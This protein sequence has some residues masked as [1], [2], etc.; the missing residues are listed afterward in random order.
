MRRADPRS[1]R[2]RAPATARWWSSSST[3]APIR[4]LTSMRLGTRRRRPRRKE[5]RALLMAR[6]GRLDC[7]DLVWLNED[8]EVVRRVTAD[9]SE[10][11][12]GCG[13]VFTAAATLGKRDLVVRLLNAGARVPPVLT[14]CRSY[15][16]ENAGILR[17]LLADG[18]LDPE[19]AR[20]AARDA[21]PRDVRPRRPRATARDSRRVC[22]DSARRGR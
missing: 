15:L 7:Y 18:G 12:A 13:G 19:S 10:A 8:D 6:G 14:A 16:L 1:I 17:L 5:L 4:A 9:P 2:R 21:A 22:R 20:L 3:T 11:N